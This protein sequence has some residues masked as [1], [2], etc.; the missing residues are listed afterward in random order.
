M[1][2]SKLFGSFTTMSSADDATLLIMKTVGKKAGAPA[3]V[4]AAK[5]FSQK[6]TTG[7]AVGVLVA[8]KMIKAANPALFCDLILVAEHL[9]Y[10]KKRTFYNIKA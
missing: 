10:R 4:L 7:F 1:R 2:G 8:I 3:A 6:F 5:T 9:R